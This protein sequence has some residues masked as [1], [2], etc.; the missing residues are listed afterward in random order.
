M[1][2]ALLRCFCRKKWLSRAAVGS[3]QTR[4]CQPGLQGTGAPQPSAVSYS[5]AMLSAAHLTLCPARG[6]LRAAVD[7]TERFWR[8][9]LHSSQELRTGPQLAALLLQVPTATGQWPQPEPVGTSAAPSTARTGASLPAVAASRLHPGHKQL[10][11]HRRSLQGPCCAILNTYL[12]PRSCS[13]QCAQLC[14]G[15][16]LVGCHKA[17]CSQ[18]QRVQPCSFC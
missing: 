16:K 2:T 13:S 14:D 1:V 11:R 15:N 6:E 18:Q 3:R 10:A 4:V 5:P 12:P 8:W 7:T 17:Q 9:G